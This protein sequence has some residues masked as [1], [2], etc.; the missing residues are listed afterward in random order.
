M[1][2]LL[3]M[4][5]SAFCEIASD[6][7]ISTKEAYIQLVTAYGA[8]LLDS[9]QPL[10]SGTFDRYQFYAEQ[11]GLFIKLRSATTVDP[12]LIAIANDYEKTTDNFL[13]TLEEIDRLQTHKPG[14]NLLKYVLYGATGQ[15]NVGVQDI[16]KEHNEAE[17][18]SEDAKELLVR[19]VQYQNR[20]D[21]S[22]LMLTT[23]AKKIAGPVGVAPI[24]LE[25][26]GEWGG[27]YCDKL[28]FIN[29]GKLTL[30]NC[31]MVVTLIG[32]NG[33]S[34][35]D[36]RFVKQW[37]SQQTFLAYYDPGETIDN[38]TV[39]RKTVSS[40]TN[41][42]VALYC[43]ELTTE[44]ITYT[45]GKDERDKIVNY[46]LDKYFEPQ[47]GY[48]PFVKGIIFDDPRRVYF[49]FNGLQL[50]PK[51]VLTVTLKKGNVTA[52]QTLAFDDWKAGDTK[53][54][55][56]RNINWDPTEWV[57]HF[58]FDDTAATCDV[59]WTR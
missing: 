40:I 19:C 17:N 57:A 48:Q 22:T 7:T 9:D 46:Y 1:S 31:T 16:E 32:I 14:M 2:T 56:F 59:R 54:M 47:S 36:V 37:S 55:Y 20:L 15:F 51:G 29:N 30:H 38:E 5:T 28:L 58:Q 43:D 26:H 50:L 4:A 44:S 45:Y 27:N 11:K 49:D 39:N 41:V 42:Q 3:T 33:E 53:C 8:N 10:Q 13:E 25:L 35:K 52:V 21:A 12:Y 34:K 6:S 18:L 24:S 23:I